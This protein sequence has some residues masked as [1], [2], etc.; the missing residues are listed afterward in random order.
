MID[1]EF[2]ANKRVLVTGHTGFKG[3]WLTTWLSMMNA[4]VYGYSLP[5]NSDSDFFERVGAIHVTKNYFG[6]IKDKLSLTEAI[7]ETAPDII[8]HL[9]AQPLVIESFHDPL[10]T[11]HTNVLGTVNL[12]EAVRTAKSKGIDVRALINVTTD[13]VYFNHHWDRGYTENDQLGGFDPY[14]ASKA[15]SELITASY[16]DSFFNINQYPEHRLGIATARAGNVIGGG[17]WSQNRLVPDCVRSLHRKETITLRNPHA[18]R[19]WQHVLEPLGAYLILAERLI[20][21]AKLYHGA[22]N[23]GPDIS[24]CRPVSEVVYGIHRLWGG[25]VKDVVEEPSVYHETDTLKLD[26]SKTISGLKWSPVWDLK[27]ALDKTVEWYKAYYNNALIDS[28]TK[29]QISC[30]M[31]H[32]RLKQTISKEH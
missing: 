12:F 21:D 5:G 32:A 31:N 20:E 4:K 18:V 30:Y 23:I 13:K 19:P 14:S 8:F 17:D 6:D 3:C 1:T 28:V 22:W 15:C 16:R 9:A 10:N 26:C 25:D 7:I 2:W 27:A 29:N 24:D 11:Y